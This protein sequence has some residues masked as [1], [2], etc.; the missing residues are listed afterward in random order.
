MQTSLRRN[1]Q[2]YDYGIIDCTTRHS[3]SH[4]HLIDDP[5]IQLPQVQQHTSTANSSFDHQPIDLNNC[6]TETQP[7]DAQDH[8]AASG[9]PGQE[10]QVVYEQQYQ[11]LL[12]PHCFG[13]NNNESVASENLYQQDTCQQLQQ[14]GQVTY[15]TI[16]YEPINFT[17]S[18]P[19]DTR[20]HNSIINE[21]IAPQSTFDGQL[22]NPAS[23]AS[24]SQH[25][26]VANEDGCTYFQYHHQPNEPE[27]VAPHS[28]ENEEPTLADHARANQAYEAEHLV[29]NSGDQALYQSIGINGVPFELSQS[30]QQVQDQQ[31]SEEAIEQRHE[32]YHQL[33]SEASYQRQSYLNFE[34]TSVNSLTRSRDSSHSSSASTSSEESSSSILTRD[35]KRAREANIPLTYYQIVNLSIDQFNEQLSKYNLSESQLTLIK[36]IRRRGKNKVAAQ[37]CRKRKMEQIYEL[38][39]EVNH[40]ANKR[41]S[42]SCECSQLIKEH[43][44]LVQEYNKI[45]AIIQEQMHQQSLQQNQF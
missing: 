16:Y 23:F 41:R 14:H 5:P 42:L 6:Y 9:Q 31:Q 10:Q 21:I 30:D 7:L 37:S 27:L 40:L 35:E 3:I 11:H 45:C 36:D 25:L 28:R 29:S 17:E 44:N 24:N 38:Q 8:L 32:E 12:G 20:A 43:G 2:Y 1:Y 15:Q 39:H 4:H 19:I 13:D 22:I 33:E 18:G 26:Q 34:S